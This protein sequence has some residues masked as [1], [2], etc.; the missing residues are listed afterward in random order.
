[1]RTKVNE[2]AKIWLGKKESDGTHKEIIDI[3][4]SYKPLARGYKVK[5]TDSWC[6]A[7]V[8]A[9]AIKCGVTDI[10]PLECSCGK[11]IEK[12]QKMGIWVEDDA[13]TPKVADII[14]YHWKDSGIGDNKSWPNH[15]GIVES[16]T[17]NT[18]KVIEGNLNNAVGY[19]NIK[20]NGKTIRGY[21]CPKYKE[22]QKAEQKSYYPQYNGKTN[23]IVDA[24]KSLKIDS[25][26]NHRKEIAKA[27]GIS[28]Y[29]GLASQNIKLLTL[30]KQGI[31]IKEK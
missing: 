1:M 28:L 4:N 17:N 29:L 31:L 6:A 12:A 19:R 14:L 22:E 27:N 15:V 30:L 18:I 2:Q 26:F 9:V 10:I 8:S 11:M 3:Y 16:V 7:F 20:V 13:Y 23:S 25:S 21:I 5:Y 24:L